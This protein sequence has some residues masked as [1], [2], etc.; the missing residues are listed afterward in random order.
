MLMIVFLDILSSNW[1]SE[2]NIFVDESK[3]FFLYIK[4]K[5]AVE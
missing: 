5:S 1:T 2:L 4:T 3:N